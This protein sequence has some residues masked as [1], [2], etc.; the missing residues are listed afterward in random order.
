MKSSDPS[1]LVDIDQYFLPH[2]GNRVCISQEWLTLHVDIYFDDPDSQME[3]VLPI[4]FEGV[5]SFF[6]SSIPGVNFFDYDHDFG[7][8][9]FD[10]IVQFGKSDWISAIEEL[11]D[12]KELNQFLI[13]LPELGVALDVAGHTLTVREPRPVEK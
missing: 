13:A 7:S 12:I 3:M 4:E 6:K 11:C 2:C 9:I 8:G 1:L 5:I 10:K